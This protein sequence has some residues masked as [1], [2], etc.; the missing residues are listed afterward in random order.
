MSG[1]HF[2]EWFHDTLLPKLPE[3]SLIVMD[4]A[5]YHS[6]HIEPTMNSR[7]GVMQDWLVAHGIE[8]PEKALK[9]ELYEL[10]K[11]SNVDDKYAIDEMAKAS[12]HEIVRLPPYHCKL[13][14]IELAWAQ[15]KRYIKKNNKLFTLTHVK[16]LTLDGFTKVG[17]ENWKK[18]VEHA[19]KIEDK[20][21]EQD[22]LYEQYLDEF[23][24]RVNK[25][26]SNDSNNSNEEDSSSK[27][28]TGRDDTSAS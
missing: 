4:N 20:F 17:P 22:E 25:D 19:I 18:L 15:V 11:L 5:S 2:E 10:I 16:E 12:G 24:I 7:K 3:R 27:D 23:I 6:R 26:S 8:F 28:D 9:R 14:P 13:N 21:W 1:E